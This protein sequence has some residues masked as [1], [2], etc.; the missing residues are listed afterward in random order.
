ML[1]YY[2]ISKFYLLLFFLCSAIWDSIYFPV[3]NV[4]MDRTAN[5]FSVINML[6]DNQNVMKRPKMAKKKKSVCYSF[7][8][9]LN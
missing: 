9:E 2:L 6:R 4:G 3:M 7:Q 5:N 1:Y 8:I